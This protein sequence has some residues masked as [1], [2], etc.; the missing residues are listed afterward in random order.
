VVRMRA[1]G[2]KPEEVPLALRVEGKIAATPVP[3]P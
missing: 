2:S 3:L 1:T